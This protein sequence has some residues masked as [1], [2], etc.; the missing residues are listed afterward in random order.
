[1]AGLVSDME[2]ADLLNVAVN[3]NCSDFS[4]LS[5][6]G[7]SNAGVAFDQQFPMFITNPLWDS[8]YILRVSSSIEDEHNNTRTGLDGLL[9]YHVLEHRQLIIAQLSC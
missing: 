3:M 6:T 1:M 2:Y 8:F 5:T 7:D 9:S 4:A